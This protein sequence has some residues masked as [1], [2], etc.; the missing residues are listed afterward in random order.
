MAHTFHLFVHNVFKKIMLFIK[1]YKCFAFLCILHWHLIIH[2]PWDEITLHDFRQL[3]L[4]DLYIKNYIHAQHQLENVFQNVEPNELYV[5]P[6]SLLMWLVQLSQV[7]T[8]YLKIQNSIKFESSRSFQ[9]YQRHITIPSTWIKGYTFKW[10]KSFKNQY[11]PHSESK[12]YQINSIKS[13]SSRSLQT[14]PKAHSNLPKF[15]A[16]I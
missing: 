3:H 5:I 13:C 4:L 6:L 7:W 1:L 11:L 16:T 8:H 15:S 14:T 2:L 12:S 9:Q 10:H